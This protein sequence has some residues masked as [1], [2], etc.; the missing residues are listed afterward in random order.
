VHA[1]LDTP[2]EERTDVSA[3]LAEWKR[4]PEE[5]MRRFDANRDGTLSEEEWEAA[6]R[7]ARGT[8][9]REYAARRALGPVNLIRRPAD[10]RQFI[11]SALP[12]EQL[13]LRFTLW[14]WLHL[15]LLA[16]GIVIVLM[17]V[18]VVVLG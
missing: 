15:T 8:I 16:G 6:R 2:A 3:L 13:V 1:A 7:E 17:A 12:P 5:L 9:E 4:D 11:I 14:A 10:G 18:G